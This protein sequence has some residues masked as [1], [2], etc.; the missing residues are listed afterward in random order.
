[1][2]DVTIYTTPVCPYCKR[3]KE[4]LNSLEI[5]F[6]EVDVAADQ[7]KRDEIIET[8]NWRTVPAIFIGEKLVGGFDD[9]NALHHT[10]KLLPLLQ[11]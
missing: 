2:K 3:A 8:H 9:I 11:D 10:G 7:A 6:R 4:L 1:M 5:P